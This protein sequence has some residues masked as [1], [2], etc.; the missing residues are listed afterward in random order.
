M[1]VHTIEVRNL[2]F[3]LD[4]QVPKHWFG[5]A[6]ACTTFWDNLSVLFP[7]GERFFMN[8]VR[9]FEA[10]LSDEKLRDEVRRFYQQEALHSREHVRYNDML[11]AHGYP[12]DAMDASVRRLL[13]DVVS[14][15][16]PEFQLAVTCGLEHFTA[17]LAQLVLSDDSPFERAHPVMAALWRW[18]AAEENEHATVAFDV[19]RAIGGG[20]ELR[21]RAMVLVTLVFWGKVLEQQVHMMRADGTLGSLSEWR[22]LGRFLLG[23]SGWLVKLARPYLAYYRP[24]FHPSELDASPLLARWREE[25]AAFAVYRDSVRPFP[26]EQGS[27]GSRRIAAAS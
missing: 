9:A 17:L 11:R 16:S 13:T 27:K 23:K 8:A 10:Q 5:G 1:S 20:Y 21:V 26:V 22:A 18:H 25:F 15:G 4:G 12:V 2:R 24:S 7:A 14:R 6:R 3:P 19:Y